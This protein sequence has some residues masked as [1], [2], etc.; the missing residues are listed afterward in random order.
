[1]AKMILMVEDD[2]G[3]AKLHRRALERAGHQVI[4]ATGVEDARHYL[5]EIV[6]DVVLSDFQLSERETG[7]ELLIEVGC[8]FPH[9]RR[10]LYSSGLPW[11]MKLAAQ[12]VAHS[13]VDDLRESEDLLTAL[14]A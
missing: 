9:T 11:H 12:V 4:V 5:D 1:M 7:A 14:A 2:A 13:V 3:T 8:R 10:V 6:F